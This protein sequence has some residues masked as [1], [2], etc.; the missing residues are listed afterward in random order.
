MTGNKNII[1]VGYTADWRP[2]RRGLSLPPV[3]DTKRHYSREAFK[4]VA[5]FLNYDSDSY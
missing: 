1:I 5:S 3:T 4:L 2:E